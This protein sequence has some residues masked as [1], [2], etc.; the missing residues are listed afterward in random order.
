MNLLKH[1][2]VLYS[3]L[4]GYLKNGGDRDKVLITMKELESTLLSAQSEITIDLDQS[5]IGLK[6][7]VS[8]DSNRFIKEE[9]GVYLL[10][11]SEPREYTISHYQFKSIH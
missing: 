10:Q 9:D 8:F 2:E 11:Y 6:L 5:Q 3:D 7:P 4:E 1:K